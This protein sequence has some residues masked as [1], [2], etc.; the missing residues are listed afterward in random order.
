[1]REIHL[2]TDGGLRPVQGWAAGTGM[3]G[4]GFIAVEAENGVASDRL[5]V[6]AALHYD[7]VTTN[8]RMELLA[9]IEG[10]AAVRGALHGD[11]QT[12]KVVLHSDSAYMINCIKDAWW[13][14]WMVKQNGGWKN[15]SKQPVEN[16]DL[17]RALLSRTLDAYHTLSG[18]YGPR[19]PWLKLANADDREAV[20]LSSERGMFVQFVK[21]KGHRGVPLNEVADQ[22]ATAG[23]NN[24]PLWE[25]GQGYKDTKA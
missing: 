10:I 22:L 15:S 3:G 20:R 7:D 21:V 11:L 24:Q 25:V 17:W 12:T 23:K 14:N 9:A 6:K 4:A 16:S 19:T 2:Y 18:T 5:I 13:Y 1:M 8:Q